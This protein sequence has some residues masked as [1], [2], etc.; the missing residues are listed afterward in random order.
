[1]FISD[2]LECLEIPLIPD[3][4]KNEISDL[5]VDVI[6]KRQD[7]LVHVYEIIQFVF[8]K[9]RKEGLLSLEEVLPDI[10]KSGAPYV[11]FFADY[12]IPLVDACD[13]HLILQ[14]MVNEYT[15][16]KPDDF[17]SLVLYLYMIAIAFAQDM[18]RYE[19]ILSREMAWKNMIHIRNE[20]LEILP[21][22]C[23]KI[24]IIPQKLPEVV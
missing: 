18:N 19:F 16:R 14:I 12:I 5:A 2:D 13:K 11:E 15:V 10:R 6:K 4:I 24:F 21:E 23:R 7:E 20:Y 1:M 22:E 8:D 9:S 3:R 17:E